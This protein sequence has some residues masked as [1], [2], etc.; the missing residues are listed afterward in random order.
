MCYA[1]PACVPPVRRLVAAP[2]SSGTRTCTGATTHTR[3]TQRQLTHAAYT[4]RG[5]H[6][7][8]TVQLSVIYT[9]SY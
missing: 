8:Q 5:R 9:R 6:Y 4:T 3:R 1:C 2:A 7:E